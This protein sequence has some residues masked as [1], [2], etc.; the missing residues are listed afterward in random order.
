M[1][2]S[3]LGS[4]LSQ[5][6]PV[7]AVTVLRWLSQL[8]WGLARNVPCVVEGASPGGSQAVFIEGLWP[9]WLAAPTQLEEQQGSC[10]RLYSQLWA[11]RSC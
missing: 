10:R 8:S 5:T 4:F 9:G 1:L 6:V 3:C 7:A 2:R 11:E